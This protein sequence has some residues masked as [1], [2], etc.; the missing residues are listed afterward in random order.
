MAFIW[1]ERLQAPGG[2]NVGKAG[3][4][5]LV[6]KSFALLVVSVGFF[7]AALGGRRLIGRNVRKLLGDPTM[8]DGLLAERRVTIAPQGCQVQYATENRFY[9]WSAVKRVEASDKQCFLVTDPNLCF[10]AI[11]NRAFASEH[12]FTRFVET[13]RRFREDAVR[14][15]VDAEVLEPNQA[16]R[17]P[18]PSGSLKSPLI[19]PAEGVPRP[20]CTPAERLGMFCVTKG[21]LFAVVTPVVGTMVLLRIAQEQNW[22][23][24]RELVLACVAVSGVCLA[25]AVLNDFLFAGL[26]FRLYLRWRTTRRITGRPDAIVAPDGPQALF[27]QVVPRENWYRRMMESATDRG[28]MVADLANHRLLFE[29]VRE[30]WVIPAEC[31]EQCVLQQAQA[32]SSPRSMDYYALLVIRDGDRLIELP[33]RA[34][35]LHELKNRPR[36]RQRA[37]TNLA[38]MIN[39]LRETPS[40]A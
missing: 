17:A 20:L 8:S 27:A 36:E 40:L 5:E 6:F 10:A 33:L 2:P 30:R 18:I 19:G 12:D 23:P 26:L 3:F 16:A 4:G 14:R 22:Q 1:F 7:G 21:F 31:I 29:G 11:P 24:P 38:S 28:W 34:R 25:I 15:E 32:G 37:A 9:P 13:C 35:N 39:S